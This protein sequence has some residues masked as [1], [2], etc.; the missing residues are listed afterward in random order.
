MSQRKLRRAIEVD[1]HALQNVIEY[2]FR[3]EHRHYEECDRP[4]NH[5]FRSVRTLARSLEGAW[6]KLMEG[7]E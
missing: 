2:L 5:I 4:R 1:L 6:E 3:D 7:N